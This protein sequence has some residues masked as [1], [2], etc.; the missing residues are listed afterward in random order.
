LAGFE[1]IRHS[2]DL[3]SGQAELLS[4]VPPARGCFLHLGNYLPGLSDGEPEVA[5]DGQCVLDAR[6]RVVEIDGSA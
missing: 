3:L 5:A 6:A 4:L 1:R 2:L